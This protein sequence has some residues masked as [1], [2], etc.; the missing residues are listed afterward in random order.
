M[1]LPSLAVLLHFVLFSVSSTI[2]ISISGYRDT[3][4][5]ITNTSSSSWRTDDEV[6]DM[7][8]SWLVKHG[9]IYHTLGEKETRFQIFKDNLNY[10]EHHN[11]GDHSYKLGLNKFADMSVEEYRL[12]YTRPKKIGS[13]RKFDNNITSDRYSLRSG[14]VLP[15]SVDWRNKGAVAAVKDQGNCG[16]CWAFSTI[17]SVEAINQIVTGDLITLSEQ[18]LKKAKV[19]SIDGYK[20]VPV[21][22][23]LSLQK[24]VVDQPVSVS[25]EASSR[26]FQ[27]YASGI[28][29]GSCG[30]D[31]DH[32][33]MFLNFYCMWNIDNSFINSSLSPPQST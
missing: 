19:V 30:I 12:L 22:D 15:D 8:L 13:K 18:N 3:H 10:I 4:M 24:A 9:K 6:N 2:D 32:T 5:T 33:W 27:N 28:F 20:D 21:N 1:K 26:D 23:E 16:C 7:Y 31:L 14:D 17:G 25:I 29:T 11:S